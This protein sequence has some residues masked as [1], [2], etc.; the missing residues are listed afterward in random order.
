MR[1]AIKRLAARPIQPFLERDEQQCQK[2]ERDRDQWF[3]VEGYMQHNLPH[4]ERRRQVGVVEE[5]VQQK[6]DRRADE[7]GQGEKPEENTRCGGET[8]PALEPGENREVVS[9]G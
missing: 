8:L 3:V 1:E 4:A 2:D 9:R 7:R 5:R 6:I